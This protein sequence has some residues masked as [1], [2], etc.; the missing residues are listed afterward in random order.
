MKTERF[1]FYQ[2]TDDIYKNAAKDIETKFDIS[3]YEWDR[4]LPKERK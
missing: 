1:I 4:L 2:K 3:N